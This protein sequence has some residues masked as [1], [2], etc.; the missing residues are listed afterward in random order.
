MIDSFTGEFRGFSNFSPHPVEVWEITFPSNEHGFVF[1]KNPSEWE[2][3]WMHLT[4]GQIK[5]KG[6]KIR[7][8]EDWEDVKVGIMRE[9]LLHKFVQHED[10]R[11][12]LLSTG[13]QVLI[14]GNNWH[15]NFWGSCR[16]DVCHGREGQ[17]WLGR[18][19]MGVR[20]HLREG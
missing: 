5:R 8:R 14:E 19:L 3:E 15:D 4:P 11:E 1:S 18:L 16:C 2:D 9:L 10:L 13:D 20:Q 7:L 17:N 6:R 12:L